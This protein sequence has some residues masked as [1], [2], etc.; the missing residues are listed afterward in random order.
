MIDDQKPLGIFG[1]TFNPIHFG[2]LRLALEIAELLELD[3]VRF[4][5]TR[6]PPH[7]SA[8]QVNASRRLDM[9]KI[10]I[11]GNSRFIVDEREIHRE[12]LCYTV[13]TLTELRNEFGTMRPLCLLMGADAFVRLC[14]WHQWQRL[15]DLAHIIVAQRPGTWF[16]SWEK[17]MPPELITEL[18]QR[19]ST[20]RCSIRNQACGKI[21][22]QTITALEISA[23]AIRRDIQKQRSLRYLLPDGVLDYIQRNKL[24]WDLDAN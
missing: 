8:H 11:E 5:P 18:R 24:Y 1:G 12:S 7:R 10:A 17:T 3:Q 9:V 19:L 21:L 13:D 2:H 15:F 22:L 4:I 14:T 6:N 16:D 23:S 20:D